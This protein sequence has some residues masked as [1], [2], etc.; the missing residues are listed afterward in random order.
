MTEQEIRNSVQ[1]LA[2]EMN[3]RLFCEQDKTDMLVG[4]ILWV[5]SVVV[6]DIVYP[7][8]KKSIWFRIRELI[9]R[10]I[11]WMKKKIKQWEV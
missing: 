9:W 8:R 11:Q 1:K 10:I 5:N 3:F 2:D 4:T 7:K 6:T